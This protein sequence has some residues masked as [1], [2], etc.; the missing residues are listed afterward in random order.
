[1]I[2]R[3]IRWGLIAAFI[4]PI[5]GAVTGTWTPEQ[6]IGAYLSVIASLFVGTVLGMIPIA[7]ILW[8]LHNETL[9]PQQEQGEKPKRKPDTDRLKAHYFDGEQVVD[10]PAFEDAQDQEGRLDES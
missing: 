6:V 2:F 7:L 10:F 4:I 3:V 5:I 1:M 9:Q 8:A